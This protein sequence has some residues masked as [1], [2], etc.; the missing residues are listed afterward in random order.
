MMPTRTFWRRRNDGDTKKPGG[1][2]MA[3]VA[4]ERWDS[5]GQRVLGQGKYSV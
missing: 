5:G 3:Q 2:R 4:A 1:C